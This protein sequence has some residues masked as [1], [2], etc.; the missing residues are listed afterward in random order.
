MTAN[1]EHPNRT[2][3]KRGEP[4]AK[5]NS[6]GRPT[7]NFIKGHTNWKITYPDL[8]EKDE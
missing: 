7:T 1:Y 8:E 5:F 4:L 6:N 2:H 3:S